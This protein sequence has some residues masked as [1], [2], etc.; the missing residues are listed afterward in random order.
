MG[1]RGFIGF[2]VDK[3]EKI[4][5]NHFDSYPEGLGA[6]VLKW[7]RGGD[8]LNRLADGVRKLEKVD[9][10]AK[11]TPEQRA[12]YALFTDSGVSEGDDWYAVLRNT[13]GDPAKI[14]EAGV[15]ADA[16]EFPQNSLYCEWGYLVDL[17]TRTFEVYRGFQTEPHDKG[18]FAHRGGTTAGYFEVALIASWSLDALPEEDAFLAELTR[19]A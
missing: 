7:A 18:R 11:P 10:D 9:E 12:R 1:T 15:Y 14:L 5:Y 8:P 17:D 16:G 19:S 13:Q 4:T 2:V 6:D 3:A